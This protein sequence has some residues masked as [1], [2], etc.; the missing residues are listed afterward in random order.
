MGC[1][2]PGSHFV[3][4]WETEAEREQPVLLADGPRAGEA[5]DICAYEARLSERRGP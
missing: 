3:N 4:L 1:A 5:V 2:R